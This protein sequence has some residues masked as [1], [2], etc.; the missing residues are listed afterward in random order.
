MDEVWYEAFPVTHVPFLFLSLSNLERVS[1][2][3]S[4]WARV[5]EMNFTEVIYILFLW[6]L[7]I[8]R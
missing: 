3:P 1:P 4:Q 5:S 8:V 6:R 2:F 7:E